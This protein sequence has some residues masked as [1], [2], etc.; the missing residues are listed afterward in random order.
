MLDFLGCS[1]EGADC[2]SMGFR[3]LELPPH[4][5]FEYTD[6]Q[7]VLHVS[8]CPAIDKS[9]GKQERWCML[10]W[11]WTGTQAAWVVFPAQLVVCRITLDCLLLILSQFPHLPNGTL[12]LTPF[13]KA[14]CDRLMK[15]VI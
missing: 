5:W 10:V 13:G 11:H 9:G 4:L 6:F 2:S 12:I 14:Q 15:S 3:A 8:F 7:S 1:T